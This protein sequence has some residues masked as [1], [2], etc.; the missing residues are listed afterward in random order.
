[1][2]RSAGNQAV[3]RVIAGRGDHPSPLSGL[4]GPVAVQRQIRTTHRGA[5]AHSGEVG[6][7]PAGHQGPPVGQVEVRTGEEIE[8]GP[9][10]TVPNV[11]ALEYS[12]ALTADSKWLQFVWFEV[13]ATTPAG[14][15]RGSG[16][17]PTTSGALPLTTSPGSPRWAVDSGAGDP[18]YEAGGAAVRSQ[19]STTMFDAPGGS[20]AAG[21]AAAMYRGQP[22]ATS[23]VFRAHF[24]T[25]LIQRRAT[26]YRVSYSASTAFT[27]SAAGP[28]A[29][30]IGY[31]VSAGGPASALPAALKAILDRDYP[32]A[33]DIR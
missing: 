18:F 19:S 23:V 17:I 33:R 20:S 5:V 21:L 28:V 13:V 9:G 31:T 3:V 30:A 7:V 6:A 29:G 26:A 16:T 2:Q 11:I 10:S 24:E 1:M 12:G 32:P 15:V 27:S 22:T 8:L 4:S 25:F 14:E